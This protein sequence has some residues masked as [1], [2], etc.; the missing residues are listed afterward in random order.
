MSF[1]DSVAG[2]DLNALSD[3]DIPRLGFRDAYFGLQLRWIG[4]AGEV[5]ADRRLLADL[6]DHFMHHAVETGADFQRIELLPSQIIERLELAH[7][8]FVNGDL[9]FDRIIADL[10]PLLLDLS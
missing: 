2:V 9:R 7:P 3:G 4:H 10:K 6:H 1:D 8:R 5:G